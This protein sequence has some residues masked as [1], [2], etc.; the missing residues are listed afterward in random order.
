MPRQHHSNKLPFC[1]LYQVQF[2]GRLRSSI[3]RKVATTNDMTSDVPTRSSWKRY[4]SRVDVDFAGDILGTPAWSSCREL[5]MF[6]GATAA[7]CCNLTSLATSSPSG[8]TSKHLPCGTSS[9]AFRVVVTVHLPGAHVLFVCCPVCEALGAAGCR[10]TGSCVPVPSCQL[11]LYR[12]G[13]VGVAVIIFV[14]L[15][16][17][18]GW[19]PSPPLDLFP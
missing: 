13:S 18:P 16:G 6:Y 3:A 17:P 19:R 2:N 14:L 4:D 8:L 5:G 7:P 15:A 12:M 1:S 10:H 11:G 9:T